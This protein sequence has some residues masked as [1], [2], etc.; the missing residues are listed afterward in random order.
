MRRS[1]ARAL[2]ACAL[3]LSGCAPTPVDVQIDFPSLQTFLHSEFG[4]L[5][6]YELEPE[7]GLGECPALLDQVDRGAF[8]EPALDSDWQ[9]ICSFREGGVRFAHVPPGPHAYV[10]IS[11]DESNTILLSGCRVAEAYEGAPPVELELFPTLDYARATDGV[12]LTCSDEQDKCQGG[13]R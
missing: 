4:R 11:R 5:F 1:P 12:V 8:G 7:Q 10:A 9:P 3:V 13:C 6:V 2:I